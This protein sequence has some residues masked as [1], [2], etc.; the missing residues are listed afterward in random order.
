[1][2]QGILFLLGPLRWAEPRAFGTLMRQRRR[3]GP[4]SDVEA[5]PGGPAATADRVIDH[6][7]PGL[8][9]A[10]HRRLAK[11]PVLIVDADSRLVMVARR[12]LA[13][14]RDDCPAWVESGA[15][16]AVGLI[17][18]HRRREGEKPGGSCATAA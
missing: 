5:V 6:L 17:V 8:A 13:G 7:G 12:P 11:D 3:G 10:P 18:P 1:M 4:W 9:P 14:N 2:L 15:K 16:R